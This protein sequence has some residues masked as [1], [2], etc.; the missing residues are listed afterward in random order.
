VEK[1]TAGIDKKSSDC[2]KRK[3]YVP[4]FTLL[5]KFGLSKQN[6]KNQTGLKS[7]FYLY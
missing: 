1:K 3:D 4:N 7:S 6:S 5:G 2:D